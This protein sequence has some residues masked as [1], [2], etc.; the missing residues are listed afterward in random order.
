QI[1]A[2]RQALVDRYNALFTNTGVRP[3]AQLAGVQSAHH[4]YVVQVPAQADRRNVFEAMR[5]ADIGVN[6]H[7]IPVHLQPYYRQL[8][9][10]AG[11]CPAAEAYYQSAITLPL[12][13]E[14]SAADQ[15]KVV[16]TLLTA[17]GNA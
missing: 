9:F 5:A 13:P 3:Q 10:A 4:L 11:H 17:I 1:V 16:S 7:Y 6:V 14:L 15:E 12:Y 8:G 2:K